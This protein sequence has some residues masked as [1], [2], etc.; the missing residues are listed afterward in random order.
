MPLD[1]LIELYRGCH[2]LLHVSWTEGLPQILYEAFAGRLPVVATDVGGIRAAVGDAVLLIA[3][4]DAAAAA[5]AVWR[6]TADADL[7]SALIDAGVERVTM[8]TYEAE[9]RRLADF[10]RDART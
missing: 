4:G 7:R 2:A 3:P 8:H 10:I 5:D 6:A 9:Q 1:T